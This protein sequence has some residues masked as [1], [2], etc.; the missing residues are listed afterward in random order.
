M[1]PTPKGPRLEVVV[2]LCER[3]GPL[4]TFE[5]M[6]LAF[7]PCYDLPMYNDKCAQRLGTLGE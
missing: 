2:I 3:F 1:P 7:F 5:L 4:M 6:F